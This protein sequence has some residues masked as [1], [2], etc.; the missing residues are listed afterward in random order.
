MFSIFTLA[1]GEINFN[2]WI[3]T[4]IKDLSGMN[5]GYCCHLV[6][7]VKLGNPLALINFFKSSPLY[8]TTVGS[9]SA[10]YVGDSL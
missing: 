3:S 10:H 2:S 5:F 1:C 4:A 7:K 9:L 8:E 6:R